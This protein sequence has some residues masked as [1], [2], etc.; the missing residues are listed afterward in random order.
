MLGKKFGILQ[1]TKCSTVL[2]HGANNLNFSDIKLH[3]ILSFVQGTELIDGEYV[4]DNEGGNDANEVDDE[5]DVVLIRVEN[6][7]EV[8]EDIV[9][10]ID[11]DEPAVTATAV[12]EAAT[13][14]PEAATVVPE[15]ATTT[16]VPEAATAVPEAATTEAATTEAATTEAATTTAAPAYNM[17]GDIEAL[18]RIRK[19]II[20]EKATTSATLASYFSELEN[21]LGKAREGVRKRAAVDN[22]LVNS[23]ASQAKKSCNL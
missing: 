10:E 2:Y 3:F 13:A 16:V 19:V 22:T 12:P 21:T 18:D 9:I 6:G 23:L 17:K 5:D 14:V 11:D 20:Q 15:A 7:E 1:F 4:E 8:I